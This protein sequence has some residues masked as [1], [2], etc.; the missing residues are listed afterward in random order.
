MGYVEAAKALAFILI[1]G[2]IVTALEW[3]GYRRADQK[4]QIRHDKEL[5]E[6]QKKSKE[7]EEKSVQL[8][9][10]IEMINRNHQDEINQ[11]H[12]DNLKLLNDGV[13]KRK[14][15]TS[16]VSKVDS[17]GGTPASATDEAEFSDEFT[18][19]LISDAFRADSVGLYAETAFN[20]VKQLCNQA[21]VVC[22]DTATNQ[23]MD[24][25]KK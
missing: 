8:S 24:D 14:V 10:Q 18:R 13:R 16:R 23:S 2:A 15:C 1:V 9:Q 5:M 25:S 20:W 6:A 3:D 22:A 17:S 21:N 19:F 4:W 11:L 7:Q 12:D